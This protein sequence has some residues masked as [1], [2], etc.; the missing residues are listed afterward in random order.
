MDL[1][2]ERDKDQNTGFVV[3]QIFRYQL[4]TFLPQ[5]SRRSSCDQDSVVGFHQAALGPTAANRRLHSE[6]GQEVIIRRGSLSY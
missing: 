6:P 2:V 4:S 1:R 3:A 5:S